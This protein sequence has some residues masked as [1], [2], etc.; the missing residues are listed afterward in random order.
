MIVIDNLMQVANQIETERGVAKEILYTAVEQA[1]AS[2]CRKRLG[3]GSQVE[4]TLDTES[5]EVVF[6][7]VKEVVE[8]VLM[9]STEI[10]LA[11]AKKIDKK[12][13]LEAEA[14]VEFVPPDF[15]RIAAQVAKQVIIQRLREAEKDSVFLEFQEKIHQI[16]NGTVQ[17][18]ENS[19]L[20]VNLGRT[21]AILRY[22]DQIPGEQF[23]P[24]EAIRVYIVD[25]EKAARGNV[26]H[27]SRTHS[28]FLKRLFE[29]EIPEIADGIIEVM[30]VSR[31]PGFRA[32]VAVKTNNP[33][34]GAVGTC[35]GQMGGR[36][37]AIINELGSNEKIDVLEWDEEVKQFIS[38]ALKP[39]KI[40]QVILTDVENKEATVVVPDDQLSLAIGKRGIN[41]RLS[42][43]L[44]GWKLNVINDADFSANQQS[45]VEKM[46]L[47]E[48]SDIESKGLAQGI[49]L[50]SSELAK[51]ISRDSENEKNIEKTQ[52]ELKEKIKSIKTE[53]AEMKVSILA[54]L[55]N[56]KTDELIKK[57]EAKGIV[58]KSNRSKL[59]PEQ[60]KEIKEKVFI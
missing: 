39:A 51:A 49:N 48:S 20:L 25:I 19:N 2:A 22:R 14:R 43:N 8:E 15:G 7:R 29:L 9:E 60:V 32:K 33:A 55:L 13:T 31:E 38:N 16:V 28:G 24:N 26:I 17:R 21:E 45:F 12:A 10:D 1:L 53:D 4:C 37:Q 46:K 27:I 57:A 18:V 52:E 5:G 58:I 50:E 6:F 44:T 23:Q 11:A 30:S 34:I 54:K 36:I 42:V 35:V 41:V 56:V 47:Q 3:D 40:S 59:T